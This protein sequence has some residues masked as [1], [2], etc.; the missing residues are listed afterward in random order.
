MQTYAQTAHVITCLIIN[1]II[2]DS[3][4][5]L[6]ISFSLFL[7]LFPSLSTSSPSS[8][9]LLLSSFFSFSHFPFLFSSALYPIFHFFVFGIRGFFVR[10]SNLL[11]TPIHFSNKQQVHKKREEKHHNVRKKEKIYNHDNMKKKREDRI[12]SSMLGGNRLCP[13]M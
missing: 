10:N 12:E 4:H 13:A 9:F 5:S 1:A 3:F 8:L 11:F 2:F 6:T 7:S